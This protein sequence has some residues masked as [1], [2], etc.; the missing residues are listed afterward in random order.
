MVQ[1]MSP[2]SEADLA[3][4]DDMLQG[5]SRTFALTIPELPGELR[6]VV[7]N[8]YL[9]CRIADTIED[10]TALTVEEKK[11]F[12]EHFVAAVAGEQSA[13]TFAEAL[14][15]RLDDSSTEDERLLV[16]DTPRV[17]RI[18]RQFSPADQQALHTCVQTMVEGME[19]FQEGQFTEGLKDERHMDTYCYHVAGV[20]GEMLTE[21]FCNHCPDIAKRRFELSQ[22][23][24]SFGQGLQMTNI[25]KD[26]WADKERS[27]CWLPRSTFDQAGFDLAN[28]SPEQRDAAFEEGLGHLIGVARY[29][30]ANALQYTLLIPPAQSGIR[31]FCLY[32]LGMAVLTLR[33]INKRRDFTSGNEVKISRRSVYA[34]VFLSKT[35]GRFN[36]PLAFLFRVLTLGLPKPPEPKP[37]QL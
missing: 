17:L 7:A 14:Y 11:A 3:W 8:A 21:L 28:L 15:P 5:V 18:T 26:I 32:A 25:L 37:A 6:T 10:S 4:Q 24:A 1:S 22:L 33:N 29:H 36:L 20:V 12:S 19:V 23:A 2:A 16:R 35:L 34:T 27:V 31:R 13:E 9:L 30:L